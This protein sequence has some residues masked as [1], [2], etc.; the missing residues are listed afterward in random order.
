MVGKQQRGQRM[1]V[2]GGVSSSGQH[3]GDVWSLELDTWT[4]T[5]VECKVGV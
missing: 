3:L 4:W 1:L 5:R 2:H